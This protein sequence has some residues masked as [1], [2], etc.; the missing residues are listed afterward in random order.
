[1]VTH[2]S[3]QAL[4]RRP[5]MRGGNGEALLRALIPEL[6][7]AV[8]LFSRIELAPGSSIGYHVHENETELFYFASGSGRVSDDGTWID[9]SAGDAMSTPSGHGHSVE[10]TGSE[11]L[12]LLAAIIK[13]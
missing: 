9:V 5:N 13:D 12:V 8:R 3:E 4:D 11:P 7:G 10:N 6:P 1:M 2:S